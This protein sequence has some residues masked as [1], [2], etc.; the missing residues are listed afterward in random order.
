MVLFHG[1]QEYRAANRSW[2]S[3][4]PAAILEV[5][6]YW[7]DISHA[8]EQRGSAVLAFQ[9]DALFRSWTSSNAVAYHTR[10]S[11]CIVDYVVDR[12][13]EAL[14]NWLRWG[15]VYC[16]PS[17]LLV[18][19]EDET[20]LRLVF[21]S[22]HQRSEQSLRIGYVAQWTP[23]NGNTEISFAVTTNEESWEEEGSHW[24]LA[25]EDGMVVSADMI[26][27]GEGTPRDI[28]DDDPSED[29]RCSWTADDFAVDA[30][31]RDDQL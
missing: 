10:I 25:V 11:E 20:H 7:L 2:D 5:A 15:S 19:R 9:L 30:A 1:Q 3:H 4:V 13:Y 14:I 28:D 8:P 22:K 27:D 12:R 23:G 29:P 26:S 16:T 18:Q 31:S 21:N 17:K 6:D 24:A